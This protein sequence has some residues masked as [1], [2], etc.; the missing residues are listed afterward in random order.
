MTGGEG[1]EAHNVIVNRVGDLHEVLGGDGGEGQALDW[2]HS[3]DDLAFKHAGLHIQA[4][5]CRQVGI[6]PASTAP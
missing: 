1:R 3:L 6:C 5:V 2:Q 4:T